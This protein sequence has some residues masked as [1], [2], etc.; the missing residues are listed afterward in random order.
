MTSPR[1]P[2]RLP[3]S[4]GRPFLGLVDRVKAEIGQRVQVRFGNQKDAPPVAAVSAV[5]TAPGHLGFPAEADA[6]VAAPSRLENDMD[7][8]DEQRSLNPP[9]RRLAGNPIRPE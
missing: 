6:A 1:F 2:C 7:L 3:P 8:I 5:R 4:P 9:E